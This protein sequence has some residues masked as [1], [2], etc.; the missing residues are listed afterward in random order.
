MQLSLINTLENDT[1]YIQ[2]T[3]VRNFTWKHWHHIR[4][5]TNG[6]DS[7]TASL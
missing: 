5:D 6:T 3:N 1:V 4:R 7:K 2:A